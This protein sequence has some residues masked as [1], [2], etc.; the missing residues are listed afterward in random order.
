MQLPIPISFPL[1]LTLIRLILSPIILPFLFVYLLPLNYVL[2]NIFLAIVFILFSLTDF[3]D[4]YI[5]RK[6][7]QESSL[8]R[9]LD[10]IADKFL[11]FSVLISLLAAGKI[12]FYWVIIL[13][14]REIFIMGLRQLALEYAI[15]IPVSWA[16][17]VKTAIQMI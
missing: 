10:P 14:G 9:L 11:I 2:I 12:F 16:G 4:G 17:K 1:F 6:Y 7:H 13:I 15:T 5:A 8:G 3:F